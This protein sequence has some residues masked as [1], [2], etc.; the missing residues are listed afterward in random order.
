MSK[1]VREEADQGEGWKEKK[2]REKERECV[3]VRASRVGK[4]GEAKDL[5]QRR[6]PDATRVIS[7]GLQSAHHSHT[8]GV[9]PVGLLLFYV[10]VGYLCTEKNANSKVMGLT[11]EHCHEISTSK[12]SSRLLLTSYA[13]LLHFYTSFSTF[14]PLPS[15]P[16]ASHS[17]SS[18]PHSNQSA[19]VND[20]GN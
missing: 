7:P 15:H 9:P 12:E 20:K 17:P 16:C 4:E 11:P 13:T 8:K 19:A 5:A 10:R 2:G 1:S 6:A 14:S 3:C 18:T